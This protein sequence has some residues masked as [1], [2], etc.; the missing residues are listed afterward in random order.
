MCIHIFFIFKCLFTN[1]FIYDILLVKYL[2]IIIG[3][4][5]IH[6]QNSKVYLMMKLKEIREEI[7]ISIHDQAEELGVCEAIMYKWNQDKDGK[8]PLRHEN[9]RKIKEYIKRHED[10]KR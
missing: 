4:I 8:I 7:P 6:N 9:V 1:K 10:N 5:M 2:F 3:V